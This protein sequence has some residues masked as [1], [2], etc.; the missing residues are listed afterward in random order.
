MRGPWARRD[1]RSEE[2]VDTPDT[3]ENLVTR[4]FAL[5]PARVRRARSEPVITRRA[6]Q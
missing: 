1:E 3:H 5:S 2:Q 6:I 4:R